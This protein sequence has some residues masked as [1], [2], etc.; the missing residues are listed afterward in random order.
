MVQPS[1]LTHLTF[2][3][4][5]NSILFYWTS[6][7]IK[8]SQGLIKYAIG[9]W[10]RPMTVLFYTKE[11]KCQSDRGVWGPQK[12]YF[13][14]YII[15][16]HCSTSLWW[17]RQKRCS[18]R[19]RQVHVIKKYHYESFFWGEID[20]EDKRRQNNGWIC[21]FSSFFSFKTIIFG[22]MLKKLAHYFFGAWSFLLVHIRFTPSEGPKGFVNWFFFFKKPDHGSWT[23]KLNRGKR[24]SSMVQLHGPWCK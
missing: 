21:F 24:P 12:T 19:K 15:H 17:E 1:Q 18:D 8:S 9:C 23:I 14:A 11:K 2:V 3:S 22:R 7:I 20:D 13:K 10:T 16:W 5:W 4:S 6:T